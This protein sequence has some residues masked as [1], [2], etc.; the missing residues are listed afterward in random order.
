MNVQWIFIFF[1]TYSLC[2]F[3]HLEPIEYVNGVAK[4]LPSFEIHDSKIIIYLND[5]SSF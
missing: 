2:G 3:Q 4:F 5:F 1:I